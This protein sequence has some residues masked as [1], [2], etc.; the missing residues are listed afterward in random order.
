MSKNIRDVE[1][2]NVKIMI[3]SGWDMYSWIKEHPDT[4]LAAGVKR[5]EKIMDLSDHVSFSF[6]SGKDSTVSAM[7]ALTEL[8]LRRLRVK[9]GIDRDGNHRVDP[10]DKKWE[11]KNLAAMNSDAEVVFTD[12]EEYGFRF[13]KHYGPRGLN[14]MNFS[15]MALELQWQSGVDF[16]SGVLTSWDPESKHN[17]IHDMPDKEKLSGFEVINTDTRDKANPIP[18]ASLSEEQQKLARE[19]NIVIKVKPEDIFEGWLVSEREKVNGKD[20]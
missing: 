15:W 1:L 3:P 2:E 6:S 4:T 16:E 18:L 9:N 7:M 20:N 11:K 8:Q 17:W 14:L 5:V 19:R 10:L 12:T 13:L